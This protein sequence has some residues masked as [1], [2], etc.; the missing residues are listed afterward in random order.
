M[1][2]ELEEVLPQIILTERAAQ[3]FKEACTA[4]GKALRNP[5]FELERNP[6]DVP[7][8]NTNWNGTV[9]KTSTPRI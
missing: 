1:S 5:T 7:A 3:V 4:E 2:T 6:A 8:G 9:R